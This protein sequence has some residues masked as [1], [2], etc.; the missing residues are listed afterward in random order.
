MNLEALSKDL[1]HQFEIR[2][3]QNGFTVV[4]PLRYED[5]D[6]VVIF[7]TPSNSG[8]LRVDDNGEAAVRLMFD[9]IDLDTPR[10]QTWLDSLRHTYGVMW[11]AE[12]ERLF[13]EVPDEA[14]LPNAIIRVAEC[15]SQMQALG[16]L[17]VERSISDFKDRI[18][19][20]LREVEKESGVAAKYDVPVDPDQQLYADAY[21]IAEK[22]SLT[23]IVAS[24]V[25]RLLEAELIWSTARRYNDPMK[26]IAVVEDAA[27]IGLKQFVRANYFTDKTV[28]YRDMAGSFHKMIADSL[29][30]YT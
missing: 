10:I 16:A 27:K 15:S 30:Q 18:I 5:G 9:G 12:D 4:T 11:S 7:V 1:C 25:E 24:T 28:Q 17:R 6:H 21:F 22:T 8:G 14:S 26:V 20:V 2:S 29:K 13:C 23:I 19:G 3:V